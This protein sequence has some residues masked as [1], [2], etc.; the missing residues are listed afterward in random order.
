MAL[1]KDE[2]RV[3]ADAFHAAAQA[4]DKYLDSNFNNISRDEYEFLNEC[5]KTLIKGATSTTTMAVGLAISDMEDPVNEI[6]GVIEKAKKRIKRLKK[7][8]R[9]IR[10]TSGL[11]DLTAGIIAKDPRAVVS[12][13][14]NLHATING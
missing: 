13:V 1:T 5:F 8:G 14:K 3:I 10:V 11:A 6:T 4:V 7:V 2:A 9:I 12:A